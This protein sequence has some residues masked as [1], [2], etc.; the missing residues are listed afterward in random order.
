M[1]IAL[2]SDHGG[3]ELKEQIKEWLEKQGYDV[4]DLGTHST[5][6]VDYPDYGVRIAE[7]VVSG[8][9]EKGIA[10]CGTGIGIS[11]AA[12]K[13]RGVRCALCASEDMAMLASSHNQANIIALG[14]RTTTF[15]E[16]QTYIQTWLN[17]PPDLGERHVRRVN[18]LTEL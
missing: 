7:T 13:I 3:F 1:K 8:E 15:E 12:N 11:I 10:F 16:A 6:S 5:D 4:L 17:T 2:A 18:K 9:A 14:G